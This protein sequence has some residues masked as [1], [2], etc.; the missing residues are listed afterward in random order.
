MPEL[1]IIIPTYNRANFLPVTLTSILNQ[2]NK[3][4]EVLIIDDGSTDNTREVVQPYLE[5]K[6]FKYYWKE[7]NERG[8]A[9]NYGAAIAQGKY[10][11]FFDSDDIMYPNHV[12]TALQIIQQYH[13]NIFHLAYDSKTNDGKLLY[14]RTK[15]S[16]S[17]LVGNP[18]SCNGIVINKSLFAQHHFVED[19]TLSASE[20]YELWFRISAY[21][22]IHHIPIITSTVIQH[23]ERS[24]MSLNLK[25]ILSRRDS[26][27]KYAFSDKM[28]KEIYSKDYNK[29]FSNWQSLIALQLL[30]YKSKREALSYYLSSVKHYPLS[31][32]TLRSF[33]IIKNLLF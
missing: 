9:R 23:D 25:K 7:N 14:S 3:N 32:I 24:V 22:T 28:V 31:S 16:N 8:A 27:F 2:S 15:L 17:I 12:S 5:D 6:R 11:N 1:S 30:L 26:F 10:L 18:Y 21:T 29:I 4:F 13:Y 20:D 19:K 33:V